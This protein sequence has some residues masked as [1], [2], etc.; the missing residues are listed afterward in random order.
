MDDRSAYGDLTPPSS[1]ARS[2]AMAI[3]YGRVVFGASML[4]APKLVGRLFAGKLVD[5]PGGAFVCRAIGAR[6]LALAL[7]VIFAERRGRPIRGWVEAGAMVDGVDSVAALFAGRGLPF[8]G[9]T[10]L[11][12]GGGALALAG[13]MAAQGAD[14][15]HDPI[16]I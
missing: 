15:P 8:F 5:A 11:V 3:A 10:L 9:R 2:M 6:D 7:G 4:L 13:G 12:L 14:D 1:D 16:I